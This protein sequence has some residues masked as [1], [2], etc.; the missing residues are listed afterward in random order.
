[1]SVRLESCSVNAV[2]HLSDSFYLT[3]LRDRVF[4]NGTIRYDEF[5]DGDDNLVRTT[6]ILASEYM[7]RS[8]GHGNFHQ[9]VEIHYNYKAVYFPFLIIKLLF[10]GC[11]VSD[12]KKYY[13]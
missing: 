10:L 7:N 4:V 9:S 12:K 6:T 3:F 11:S 5:T 2:Q 8:N 1:M 13:F